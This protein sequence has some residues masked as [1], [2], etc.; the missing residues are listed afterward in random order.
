MSR[1]EPDLEGQM[2][3]ELVSIAT[4][5]LIVIDLILRPLLVLCMYL[6]YL[7]SIASRLDS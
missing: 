1:N 6:I 5:L 7:I 2:L 4:V 3:M